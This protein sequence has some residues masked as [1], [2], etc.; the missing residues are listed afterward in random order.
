VAIGDF[1]TG[2][3]TVQVD[4]KTFQTLIDAN[5]E[6][7]TKKNPQKS[8]IFVRKL[9]QEPKEPGIENGISPQLKQT[10]S[11]PFLSEIHGGANFAKHAR[12]Q[13]V[14]DR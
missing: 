10:S 14:V 3:P 2:K 13:F 11:Q 4:K 1:L 6:I 8:L 9:P 5:P 12:S 7:W